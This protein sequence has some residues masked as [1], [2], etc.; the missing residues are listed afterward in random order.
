MNLSNQIQI[1]P[2]LELA[3]L[4]KRFQIH[5]R[6]L[7]VF[8]FKVIIDQVLNEK[9]HALLSFLISHQPFLEMSYF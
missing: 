7:W 6:H 3:Y 5:L 1:V 9:K 8:D 4:V 2:N